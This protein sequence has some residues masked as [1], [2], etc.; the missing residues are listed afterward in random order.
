MRRYIVT[1]PYHGE[2]YS[3]WCVVR[4]D[5]D[6]EAYD[7]RESRRSRAEAEACAA[8]P[9]AAEPDDEDEAERMIEAHQED[10][11]DWSSRLYRGNR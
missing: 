3:L 1:G 6:G 7:V 11:E 4:L 5:G 9:N 10:R 2:S 8:R